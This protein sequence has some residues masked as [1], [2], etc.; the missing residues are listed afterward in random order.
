MAEEVT[1]TS[2]KENP[3]P[4]PKPQGL[5]PLQAG[6][7][8]AG[9][10]AALGGPVGLLAGVLAGAVAKRGR[11]NYLDYI[12]RDMHNTEAEYAGLQ[13][14]IRS[15]LE[16]ADSDEKRL[17]ESAKRLATD[18]KMRMM[19]G[20]VTGR[21]MIEQANEIVRGIMNADIQQ[22]K[23]E[24]A[25][26]FNTQ[27]GLIS[28]AA[29]TFRDQYSGVISQTRQMDSMSERV[30]KLT[31]DPTFDP[32]K[33]FNRA[34]LA[35]LIS[36]GVGG[37]FRD[38]P[39][40]FLAGVAQGG[41]GTIVGAIA[42]GAKT[43]IDSDEFKVSKEDYNR[44]ALNARQVTMQYART[45][46]QE[47]EQQASGLDNFAKQVGVIPRN[48]NMAAYVTGGVKELDIAP[49]IKI[50]EIKTEVKHQP[51]R[52]SS[53]WQPTQ[54]QRAIQPLQAPPIEFLS[55]DWFRS[56][57]GIPTQRQRRPTN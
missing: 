32:N 57:L 46:L 35:E 40:G 34:V 38:D 24:Q 43:W 23:V 50:P 18:G 14:E 25:A 15:E 22:R 41:Q 29:T 6:L 7:L 5:S 44:I 9:A 36:T 20:D 51:N 42:Q 19:S 17:L 11:D 45:R 55:D 31:A 2:P 21:P 48:Y 54:R 39:N 27:R 47:I 1:V 49:E 16:I 52:S 53:Q 56:K 12:A 8:Y 4:R 10:G 28:N 26:Q 13:D 33:P 30:L 3:Y 37:M